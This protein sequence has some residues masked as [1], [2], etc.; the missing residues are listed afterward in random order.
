MLLGWREQGG[1][2]DSRRDAKGKKG[3]GVSGETL[4]LW[5]ERAF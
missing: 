5:E 1:D 2:G 3:M 4:G